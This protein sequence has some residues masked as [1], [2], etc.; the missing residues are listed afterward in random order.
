[1]VWR[2]RVGLVL[3]CLAQLAHAFTPDTPDGECAAAWQAHGIAASSTLFDPA[4][5]ESYDAFYR[6]LQRDRCFKEWLVVIYMAADNSLSP[7]SYRDLWEM[8]AAGSSLEVD[9]VAFHDSAN[10]DGF[11]YYHI[12]HRAHQHDYRLDLPAFVQAQEL[13]EATPEQQEEAYLNAHGPEL[14][15]SPAVETLPEGNSASRESIAAFLQWALTH[16]PSRRVLFVGWSHGAGFAAPAEEGAKR[17]RFAV[18]LAQHD[19]LPVSEVTSAVREAQAKYRGGTP[20][21]VF[22]SDACLNQQVEFGF[23]WLGLAD[24]VFGSST[25]VQNKGF[26]YRSLLGTFNRAPQAPT[27]DL[28]RKIPALYGRSVTE[29]AGHKYSSYYDPNATMATWTMSEL[30][31]LK[32][33]WETLADRL[34]AWVEAAAG[35]ERTNRIEELKKTFARGLRLGGT[36]TDMYNLLQVLEVWAKGARDANRDGQA[37]FWQSVCAA[38]NGANDALENSVWARFI[39]SAYQQGLVLTSKGVAIWLPASA[40]EYRQLFPTFARSQFYAGAPPQAL[41]TW[42]QLVQRV[43]GR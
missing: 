32:R 24:Y 3:F 2:A 7:Y 1:M 36:S 26:N 29:R 27:A 22:G 16:Y 35:V 39:G 9:T 37:D 41:S 20:F 19:Y 33:A 38:I 31:A 14:V 28:A 21:D 40:S 34:N 4:G 6:R 17:F 8:Q 5:P 13:D 12:A 25:I 10:Q 11:R 42:A 43:Y 23:E 18:D 15:V 30:P